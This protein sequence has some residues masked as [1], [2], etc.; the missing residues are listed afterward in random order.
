MSVFTDASTA[1]EFRFLRSEIQRGD[2]TR[3]QGRYTSD[4]RPGI[5]HITNEIKKRIYDVAA[6]G[7]LDFVLVEI[8]GTVGDIE[9]IPF[10]ESIRQIREELGSSRVMNIH[11]TLVPEITVAGEQKTKPAQHSVRE[12][13]AAG[14]IPDMLLTRTSR[15]LSDEM[16]SK[17]ALFCNV[18]EKYVI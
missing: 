5:P 2:P 12:L 9:G 8:G 7:K 6:E 3:A 15:P 4:G 17:V 10:L 14:I 11:L 18:R 13:M 1:E 16:K